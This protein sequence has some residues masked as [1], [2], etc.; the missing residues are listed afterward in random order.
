MRITKL[1]LICCALS[2]LAVLT[3]GCGGRAAMG[4][5][6]PVVDDG[7]LYFGSKT[8]KVY[9]LDLATREPLWSFPAEGVLAGI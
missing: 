3:A 2:L 9:A 8:G 1:A 4:W 7:T 5:S 6:A